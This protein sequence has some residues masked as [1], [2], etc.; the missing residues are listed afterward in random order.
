MSAFFLTYFKSMGNKTPS[1][2]K[3]LSNAMHKGISGKDERAQWC[4]IIGITGIIFI[5]PTDTI[6]VFQLTCWKEKQGL[7][8]RKNRINLGL[9]FT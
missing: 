3:W 2:I 6:F 8:G 7:V 1:G 4:K 9:F 5:S